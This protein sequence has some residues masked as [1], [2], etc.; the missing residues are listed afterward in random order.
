MWVLAGDCIADTNFESTCKLGLNVAS[1]YM[2]NQIT[3]IIITILLVVEMHNIYDGWNIV[4]MG[5]AV[6][7]PCTNLIQIFAA[8]TEDGQSF[9]V[10]AAI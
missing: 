8:F 6:V 1:G 4:I 10:G 2:M 9:S 5:P 7:L 3:F